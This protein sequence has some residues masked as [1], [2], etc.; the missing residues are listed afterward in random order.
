MRRYLLIE[1]G[2]PE[3]IKMCIYAK[4][5]GQDL[6]VHQLADELGLGL[7]SI[8]DIANICKL[9]ESLSCIN[10]RYKY[11]CEL[12]RAQFR[13]IPSDLIK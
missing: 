7:I 8:E 3:G 10:C 6:Y 12:I 5:H 9:S 11:E 4:G 2:T 13:K 1:D